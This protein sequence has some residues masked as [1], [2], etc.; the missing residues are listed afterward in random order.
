MAERRPS[1]PRRARRTA[2]QPLRVTPCA[3]GRP[4]FPKHEWWIWP[5]GLATPAPSR[6]WVSSNCASVIPFGWKY[7]AIATPS[8]SLFDGSAWSLVEL[9]IQQRQI[10]PRSPCF[11]R[12][13]SPRRGRV[14]RHDRRAD[15]RARLAPR[16]PGRE[17][18]DGPPGSLCITGSARRH[19]KASCTCSW[20]CRPM[21]SRGWLTASTS[22]TTDS[23]S[24]GGGTRRAG[25]ISACADSIGHPPRMVHHV[26][27]HEPCSAEAVRGGLPTHSHG[28]SLLFVRRR[29]R[30]GPSW[31]TTPAPSS[32][33]SLAD[34]KP[35]FRSQNGRRAASDG[36]Q[37]EA[38]RGLHAAS[39]SE[40]AF[41]S[42][43]A[44]GWALPQAPGQ[45]H[46]PGTWGS[47]A[48][49]AGQGSGRRC[50][51]PRKPWV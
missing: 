23:M 36:R 51:G 24:W 48:R 1:R 33:L 18:A 39:S 10:G 29:K 42:P 49:S 26:P 2:P 45:P 32:A 28:V 37:R 50:E 20:G 41:R 16:S 3:T 27:R 17:D 47:P 46:V 15:P 31:R 34:E 6:P 40:C 11:A 22:E 14:D 19:V 30:Q 35:S 7:T 25:W 8:P 12:P 4:S 21:T 13:A 5:P 38:V 43:L 44:G 9:P